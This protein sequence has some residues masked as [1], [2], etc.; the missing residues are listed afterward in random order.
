MRFNPRLLNYFRSKPSQQGVRDV[1]FRFYLR[2]L[3]YFRH[4]VLLIS[5]VLLLIGCTVRLVCSGPGRWG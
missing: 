1:D 5:T 2:V 4:D 3:G